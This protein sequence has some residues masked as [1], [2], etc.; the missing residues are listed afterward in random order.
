MSFKEGQQFSLKEID[1]PYES[2][3]NFTKLSTE[4]LEE[5][6]KHTLIFVY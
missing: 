4:G 6:W 2:G 1:Q 5:L 3:V